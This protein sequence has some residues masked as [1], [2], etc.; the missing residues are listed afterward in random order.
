[1]AL[2]CSFISSARRASIS[3]ASMRRARPWAMFHVRGN[4]QPRRR[5]TPAIAALRFPIQSRGARLQ[6]ASCASSADTC[7]SFPVFCSLSFIG[8]SMVLTMTKPIEAG[9]WMP[10]GEVLGRL[11]A[12]LAAQRDKRGGHVGAHTLD[13]VTASCPRQGGSDDL[14]RRTVGKGLA[15]RDPIQRPASADVFGCAMHASGGNDGAHDL[16]PLLPSKSSTT[17]SPEADKR[18][19]SSQ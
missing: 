9:T 10:I 17:T 13:N 11:A 12:K 4:A 8:F 15:G 6:I 19:R 7:T 14:A 5:A 1:M 2:S 16:R 3:C 18:V